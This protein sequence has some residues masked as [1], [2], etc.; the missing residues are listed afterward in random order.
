MK[1]LNVYYC[2]DEGSFYFIKESIK[3]LKLSWIERKKLQWFIID[4]S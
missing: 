1:N 2:E 4:L 3:L